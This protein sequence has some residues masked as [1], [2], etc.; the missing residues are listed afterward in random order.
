MCCSTCLLLDLT[1]SLSASASQGLWC[2]LGKRE[3]ADI[4][5]E[6]FKSK[7]LDDVQT[8]WDHDHSFTAGLQNHRGS[9]RTV[10]NARSEPVRLVFG[11]C[12]CFNELTPLVFENRLCLHV[13]VRANSLLS[14]FTVV[15]KGH[16]LFHSKNDLALTS[17]PNFYVARQL[18][19]HQHPRVD[20]LLFSFCFN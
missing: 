13:C 16:R 18:E 7:H 8:D 5:T 19:R 9:W 2:V 12:S 17:E 6:R 3:D 4:I 10:G 14:L 11:Q 20:S 1:I 15:I